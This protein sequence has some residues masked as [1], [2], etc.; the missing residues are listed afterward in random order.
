MNI[1]QFVQNNA[2]NIEKVSK[3][4]NLSVASI[5]GVT[6]KKDINQLTV[7]QLKA[8]HAAFNI[9]YNEILNEKVFTPQ[10][11]DKQSDNELIS[12]SYFNKEELFALKELAQSKLQENSLA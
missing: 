3:A 12:E 7:S 6:G 4:L 2:L 1:L 10:N 11:I 9:P 8:I 5:K